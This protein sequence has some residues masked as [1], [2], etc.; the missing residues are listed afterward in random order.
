[1][2]SREKVPLALPVVGGEISFQG[3][4]VRCLEQRT[5]PLYL[6]ILRGFHFRDDPDTHPE[7]FHRM[8]DLPAAARKELEEYAKLLA[9]GGKTNG[10]PRTN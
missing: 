2:N 1:M 5:P 3:F 9:D 6:G 10:L 4:R 8:A 7:D